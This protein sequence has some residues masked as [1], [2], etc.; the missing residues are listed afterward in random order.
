M[1]YPRILRAFAANPFA[2]MPEKAL[3][4]IAFL[5]LKSAGVMLTPDQVAE[6]IGRQPGAH[7]RTPVLEMVDIE[8]GLRTYDDGSEPIFSAKPDAQTKNA[9]GQVAV[10]NLFG[11]VNQRAS[12]DI[13][14]ESVSCE[15]VAKSLRS[16]VADDTVKAIV[17]N[18]DSP[19]GGVYGVAELADTIF[20][21]RGPK[22]IV[23]QAN[24]LMASAAYWLG[25]AAD[26]IVV[27]PSGEIGSI[28]VYG[29]HQDWSKA[30]DD[31]GVKFTLIKAGKFKAEGV[32]FAP[33]TDEAAAYMQKRVDEY[34][35]DFTKAVARGRGV[36]LADVRSGFGE[37]RCVGAQEAVRLRMADRVGT[38][39][40]TLARL[41]VKTP[42]APTRAAA[43]AAAPLAEEPAAQDPQAEPPKAEEPAPPAVD[44]DHARRQHRNQLRQRGAFV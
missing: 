43:P 20:K 6:R 30:Y 21:S 25:S 44:H 33:L 10:I 4:I 36:Q 2:L 5:E 31:A 13:S 22:P 38:L 15:R 3:Q 14:S 29:V 27:T 11:V 37:G 1:N 9:T 39:D 17:L 34:Y 12:G 26:E 16:A 18:I 42:P 24:S 41:G 40:D 32:D 8:T 19:G 7:A 35:G 23:A 28:G